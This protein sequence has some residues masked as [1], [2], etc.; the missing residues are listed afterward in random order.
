MQA[1]PFSKTVNQIKT[2]AEIVDSD[3]ELV[4][5]LADSS[6]VSIYCKD[7][8][9]IERIYFNALQNHIVEVQVVT[10][11]MTQEPALPI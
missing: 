11:K 8:N 9:V 4:L 7:E 2:Y 6:Y 3:C 1:F 10:M 5:L